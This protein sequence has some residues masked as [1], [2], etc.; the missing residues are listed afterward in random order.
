V[1]ANQS[2]D[3]LAPDNPIAAELAQMRETLDEIRKK[4]TTRAGG[5]SSTAQRTI[6]A[7]R[8]VIE[9]NIT[10][11]TEEDFDLL[12]GRSLSDVQNTWAEELQVKWQELQGG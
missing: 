8:S 1:A 9:R 12:F 3:E 11:L 10:H 7:L 6:N 2:V 4:V 5:T